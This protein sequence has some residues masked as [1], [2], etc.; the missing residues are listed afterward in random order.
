MAEYLSDAPSRVLSLQVNSQGSSSVAAVHH[1]PSCSHDPDIHQNKMKPGE[2]VRPALV[3]RTEINFQVL[4]EQGCYSSRQRT[5]HDVAEIANSKP[6]SSA[7]TCNDSCGTRASVDRVVEE[8]RCYPRGECALG[9]CGND[10][11]VSPPA[12]RRHRNLPLRVV[13]SS[14]FARLS[15][16]NI[17]MKLSEFIVSFVDFFHFLSLTFLSYIFHLGKASTM[18]RGCAGCISMRYVSVR[19]PGKSISS[20]S[21]SAFLRCKVHI[22]SSLWTCH[23]NNHGG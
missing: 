13:C 12:C 8:I 14:L 18:C 7:S 2:S 21:G 6:C 19:D 9:Y 5:E 4:V 17:R 10:E 1:K 22:S 23:S 16:P 20:K 3:R 15:S 11:P